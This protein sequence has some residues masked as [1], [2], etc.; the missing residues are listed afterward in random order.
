MTENMIT[1][2]VGLLFTICV[3][4]ITIASTR[5]QHAQFRRECEESQENTRS[6]VREMRRILQEV[7]AQMER[8]SCKLE[9]HE[10]VVIDNHQEI[11][12]DLVTAVKEIKLDVEELKRRPICAP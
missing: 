2:G 8:A 12:K 7:A 6:Q 5:L 4:A 11:L 10:D 3:V 1:V 9:R